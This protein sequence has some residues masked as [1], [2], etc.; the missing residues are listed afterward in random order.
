MLSRNALQTRLNIADIALPAAAAP[1]PAAGA[2]AA[3]GAPEAEKAPEAPKEK[4]AFTITLTKID[5]AQKA[6][7]IK[8]VKTIMPSMNLVEVR[9]FRQLW[10]LSA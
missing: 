10:A 8:E 7:V 4:T 1:G 2:A 6:K 3:G 5:S 9:S